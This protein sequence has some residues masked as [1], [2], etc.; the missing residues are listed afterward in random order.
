MV[1][2]ILWT[3]QGQKNNESKTKIPKIK[4]KSKKKQKYAF[5]AK[6]GYKMAKTHPSQNLKYKISIKQC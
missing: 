3:K 6:N 5:L 2:S 1:Y 4:S